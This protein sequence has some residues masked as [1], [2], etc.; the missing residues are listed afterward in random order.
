MRRCAAVAQYYMILRELREL[1]EISV[2]L[3]Y[4]LVHCAA[5]AQYYMI[6]RELRERSVPLY[7]HLAICRCGAVTQYYMILQELRELREIYVPLYYHL[8]I[9]PLRRCGAILYDIVGIAG[10]ARSIC[11]LIL[12]SLRCSAA[13]LW[14]NII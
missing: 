11:G 14:H 1:R 13:A 12:P 6:L 9:A 4:H 10:I 3:Y 2:P 7:Y 5:A 8:G